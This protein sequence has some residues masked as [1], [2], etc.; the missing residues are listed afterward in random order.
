MDRALAEVGSG[1]MS[2]FRRRIQFSSFGG[3]GYELECGPGG[4]RK[5]AFGGRFAETQWIRIGFIYSTTPCRIE[6]TVIHASA[7]PWLN[8]LW[9]STGS[10]L[11]PP[12][13][14]WCECPTEPEQRFCEDCLRLFVSSYY[15]CQR[16]AS[17]LPPVV[18]NDAC[19]RC[20]EAKWRFSAVMTLGPYRGRLREAVILMKKKPFEL[21]RRGVGEL[22]TEELLKQSMDSS[23]LLISVPNHWTRTWF[24]SVCQASSLAESVSNSSGFPLLRGVVRRSRRTAKQ[25][26]LSWTERTNNVRGAFKLQPT[27]RIVGKHV[28]VIDDVLTSGATANEIA[29]LLLKGGAAQVSVAVAARG[30]GAREVV[31]VDKGKE[32]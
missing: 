24:R 31:L 3:C 2:G 30:T 14:V 9:H 16:C 13:C 18:P 26:M 27:K 17:P 29:K 11:C 21:L 1:L 22:M 7:A 6:A 32:Q 23:P 10:M 4:L 20:T 19:S 25:G 15:R 8:Q 5:A 12:E 28:I